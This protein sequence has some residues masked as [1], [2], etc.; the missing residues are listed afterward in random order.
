MAVMV[1]FSS[2]DLV[3]VVGSMN[4]G[5]SQQENTLNGQLQQISQNPAAVSP[6]QLA[7]F[8]ANLQVWATVVQMES[9]IIKTY[10]DVSK[11]IVSNMGS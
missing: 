10:G 6:A 7:V 4:G 9:S 2:F 11:Q 5:I 3:N 1:P 8:Q